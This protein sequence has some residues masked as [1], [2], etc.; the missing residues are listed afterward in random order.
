MGERPQRATVLHERDHDQL[1]NTVDNAT[2]DT[3]IVLDCPNC[4][5]LIGLGPH[6]GPHGF[7]LPW[8]A[9]LCP[10]CG[11]RFRVH[12]RIEITWDTPTHPRGARESEA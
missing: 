1:T 9:A 4:Q 7:N 11:A 12:Q 10:V 3:D 6:T 2:S 5:T 8:L